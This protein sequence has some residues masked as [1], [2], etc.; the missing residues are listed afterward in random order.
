[1]GL[2]GAYFACGFAGYLALDELHVILGR[3]FPP[4]PIPNLVYYQSELLT[5]II[6]AAIGLWIFFKKKRRPHGRLVTWIISKLT[7][8]NL[9]FAF[10]IGAFISITSFPASIPYLVALGKYSTLRLNLSEVIGWILFYN[11]GYALPMILI[12][13]F[14]LKARRKIDFDHD[15]LHEHANTLNRHLTTWTMVGFGLLFMVD[16]GYYFTLGHALIKG[17]YF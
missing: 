16:A 3:L 10:G 5:G 2:S 17:R 6:M 4:R 7:N 9:W 15:T 11:L 13:A 8:M 1:V 12:L 14:Y